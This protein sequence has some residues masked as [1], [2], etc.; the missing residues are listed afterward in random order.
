M[1]KQIKTKKKKTPTNNYIVF[2]E[3]KT[4]YIY[5]WCAITDGASLEESCLLF[6]EENVYCL[7]QNN[8][9]YRFNKNQR[10]V[11]ITKPALWERVKFNT[12]KLDSKENI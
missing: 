12:Y 2:T 7:R 10:I 5:N 3:Q 9:L 8:E 1:N 11:D 6:T 4:E